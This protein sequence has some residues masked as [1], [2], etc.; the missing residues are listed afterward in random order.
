MFEN[1][2]EN[3]PEYSHLRIINKGLAILVGL[4]VKLKTWA[5]FPLC[6]CADKPPGQWQGGEGA[7][8][9][10][11]VSKSLKNICFKREK[12]KHV[13]LAKSLERK[14]ATEYRKL[15]LTV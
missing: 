13:K 14:T 7:S 1:M 5:N 9:Y 2:L 12:K 8:K 3:A 4:I 15:I 10:G 6:V 11:I